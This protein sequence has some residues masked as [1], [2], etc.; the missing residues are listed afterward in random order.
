MANNEFLAE[1]QT[2]VG[3]SDVSAI[4]GLNPW[5]DIVDL[6]REKT[7]EIEPA[8]E[9]DAMR[10]GSLL[11]PLIRDEY[12]RITGNCVRVVESLFRH[13]VH[14]HIIGHVD[15]IVETD[16]GNG[17]L[18]IKSTELYMRSRWGASMTD[19][20]PHNYLLQVQH[21]MLVTG[22]KWAHVAVLFGKRD[23]VV[24]EVHESHELQQ[25]IVDA[26][27]DFWAHVEN[28]TVPTLDGV[29]TPKEP[30]VYGEENLIDALDDTAEMFVRR[31]SEVKKHIGELRAEENDL[32]SA[33]IESLGE[34][35]G[36]QTDDYK[37]TVSQVAQNQTNWR[38]V[39]K[40]ANVPEDIINK[41]TIIKSYARLNTSGR[42]FP[43][44]RSK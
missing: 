6:Y 20:I 23:F 34:Y 2:G 33:I 31:Y 16:N 41:H 36:V 28:K 30:K 17:V 26:C 35:S 27:N 22:L 15:G 9:T 25:L 12:T 32:K 7:G 4:L 14:S 24:F 10:W 38:A 42:L 29:S 8:P 13:P 21:Y 44:N 39:A 19:E 5:R 1:R 18:E 43:K 3:G 40:E 11:E 37:V